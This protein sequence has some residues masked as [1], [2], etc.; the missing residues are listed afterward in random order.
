MRVTKLE[1]DD[2]GNKVVRTGILIPKSDKKTIA[3]I[4]TAILAAAEKK[5]GP[6]GANIFKSSK[7]HNPLLDADELADDPESSVGEESRGNYL[8]N[9]KAYKIP[10]VVNKF[11]ER[12]LDPDELEEICVS[13]YYFYFSL[14]FKGFD[15]ESKGVRVLLNNLMFVAEGERL[16]GGKSAED[17]FS[18]YAMEDDD[19]DEDDSED[20]ND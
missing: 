3:K 1:E 8:L 13:G 10:Q 9:A 12:I 19:A 2:N 15:N 11:N 6:R 7:L 14:T 4:R 18:D 20:W 16:D 17:E 5:L